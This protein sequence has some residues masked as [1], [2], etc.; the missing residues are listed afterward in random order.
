MSNFHTAKEKAAEML[1]APPDAISWFNFGARYAICLMQMTDF[2]E[3]AGR[4]DEA[5]DV[6]SQF[7]TGKAETQ[8]EIARNFLRIGLYLDEVELLAAA[9]QE[10][11]SL[12]TMLDIVR[13]NLEKSK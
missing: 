6:V 3:R 5:E 13:T 11:L 1:N 8:G 7:E 9:H 4:E 12:E 2:Y 10:G